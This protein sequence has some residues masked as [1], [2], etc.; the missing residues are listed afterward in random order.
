[1]RL[2]RVR[3]SESACVPLSASRSDG[4]ALQGQLQ[5][6]LRRT[7]TSAQPIVQSDKMVSCDLCQKTLPGGMGRG[8]WNGNFGK[9]VLVCMKRLGQPATVSAIARPA[10]ASLPTNAHEAPSQDRRKPDVSVAVPAFTTRVRA[11]PRG[12]KT[13]VKSGSSE[14]STV[15]HTT[16]HALHS[17]P[18]SSILT[19]ENATGRSEPRCSRCLPPRRQCK[20]CSFRPGGMFYKRPIGKATSS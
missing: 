20:R 10:V 12:V 19:A 1:M 18:Q 4:G 16:Q 14:P 9:H 7:S 15:A 11:P 6:S 3:A 13:G 2:M 8:T 17:E 5:S